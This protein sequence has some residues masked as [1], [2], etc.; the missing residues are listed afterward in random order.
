[1]QASLTTASR[2]APRRLRS[3]EERAVVFH[4]DLFWQIDGELTTQGYG[5][6]AG[7]IA[8]EVRLVNAD[9]SVT[10][11]QIDDLAPSFIKT[12]ESLALEDIADGR[13]AA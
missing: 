4:S 10:A 9:G 2:H 11:D 1:M 3:D 7:Y 8:I 12:L 5:H 6:P 13:R